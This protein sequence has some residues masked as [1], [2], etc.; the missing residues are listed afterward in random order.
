MKYFVELACDDI[1]AISAN[2]YKFIKDEGVLDDVKYGWNFV[3]CKHLVAQNAE[4]LAFFKQH[5]LIPRHTAV[6]IVEN[7][8]HLPRH[9]DELPVTA[10][11][12]IPVIN[13]EGWANRWYIN[14]ILVAELLNMRLPIVFNSQIEHSVE[15]ID[16][17][18]FPRIIASFTFHNEPLDLLK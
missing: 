2:I 15:L 12:N 4:L 10:K 6:T 5:N 7:N 16:A 11:I 17:S 13:T 14:D 18:Q 8:S 9:T 1:E 3:D